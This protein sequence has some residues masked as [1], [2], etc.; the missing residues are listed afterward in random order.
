MPPHN[1]PELALIV[2]CMNEEPVLPGSAEVFK[3]KFES[4]I[5]RGMIAA[6]SRIYF[7]DD[8]STDGTWATICQLAESDELIQ[9]LDA[10]EMVVVKGR[11]Q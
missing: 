8:G 2:P 9:R 1:T 6:S 11:S 4:L 7:I 10:V 5:E 3:S